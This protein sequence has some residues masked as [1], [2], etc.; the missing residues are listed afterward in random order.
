MAED[1]V[2]R[3]TDLLARL[4]RVVAAMAQDTQWHDQMFDLVADIEELQCQL[5]PVNTT[6]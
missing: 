3:V 6:T 1:N 4:A 5:D 2:R